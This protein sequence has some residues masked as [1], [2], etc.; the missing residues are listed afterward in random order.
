MKIVFLRKGS[1]AAT[2]LRRLALTAS[3][4]FLALSSQVLQAA[5]T[6]A[7][8]SGHSGGALSSI[9]KN[10][11]AGAEL[12]DLSIRINL[13]PFGYR[14]NNRKG[15]SR[16]IQRGYSNSPRR[17]FGNRY[18]HNKRFSGYSSYDRYGR[19]IYKEHRRKAGSNFGRNYGRSRNFGRSYRRY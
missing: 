3:V 12:T 5:P 6:G 1:F 2:L 10:L 8:S 13:N 14:N 19:P 4:G 9:D 7:L 18:P 15:N 16:R 11:E 17:S